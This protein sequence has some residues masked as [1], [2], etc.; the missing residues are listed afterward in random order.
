MT[1]PQR[2][3]RRAINEPGH[4]HELTFSCYGRR[5]FLKSERSCRWLADALDAARA[6]HDFDLFAYVFMPEHVHVIVCPRNREY[7][8]AAILKSI[9]QSVARRAVAYLR[10]HDPASLDR[11]RV[12]RGRRVEHRF[13]QA[14][15]GYDRNITGG[16]MLAAMID[17]VHANP[18]R[19]GLCERPADWTWSS[20]GWFL[21]PPEPRNNLRPDPVPPDWAED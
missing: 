8:M 3:R 16:R 15:G 4:A 12:Q 21:E 13:W 10:E 19:R 18:V 5:P 17:Y 2:P 14:G 11:I 20:A 9:K 1:H 7:A 6:A